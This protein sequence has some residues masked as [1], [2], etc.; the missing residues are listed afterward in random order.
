M[1]LNQSELA[2]LIALAADTFS[3]VAQSHQN[4]ALAPLPSL[5]EVKGRLAA[6][7]FAAEC[8]DKALLRWT[9]EQLCGFD[10]NLSDPNYFGVFN[11]NPSAMGVVGDFFASARN[12]QLASAVSSPF[13]VVVEDHLIKFFA[14]HLRLDGPESGGIFTSGG[15]EANYS[16]VLCALAERFPEFEEGGLRAISGLPRIYVSSETHHSFLKAAKMVGLGLAAIVELPVT[17][18]LKFDI[19]ALRVQISQDR[20][21]G[22]IPLLIVGTLGSTSAGV[23]DDL[24]GLASLATQEKCWFHVDAAWGGAA[25]L[26]PEFAALFDGCQTADSLTLD[27]HKW[28]NVPMT[29]GMFFCRRNRVLEKAFRVTAS[30]YMPTDSEDVAPPYHRSMGWSRRFIGLKLF[31]SLASAGVPGY[32]RVLRQ[33]IEMGRELRKKLSAAGWHLENETP[34]PVVCFSDERASAGE[35]AK[36]VAAAG[37]AWVTTTQLT[38]HGKTVLRAGISNGLTGLEHL[39][40]LIEQL[41]L[42]RAKAAKA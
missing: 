35:V 21:Q 14:K 13:G 37:K 5:T 17:P 24:S 12:S 19:A 8:D 6:F 22:N 20:L 38:H 40:M 7:T 41:E 33:Q 16:A 2:S 11:P 3:T 1:F 34:L 23:I 10:F 27:A 18:D 31:L 4:D 26:L 36:A 42:A 30:P 28:L 39:T 15:T 9:A 32:Q 29:A 25:C